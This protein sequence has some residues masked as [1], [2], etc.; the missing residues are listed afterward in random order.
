M[1]DKIIQL[2][3]KY[4]ELIKYG[5]FGVLTT[6]VNYVCYYILTRG[7]AIG[8][9]TS[10][11]IAFILS[12]LF[13]YVTNRK[14]VFESVTKGKEQLAEFAKFCLARVSGLFLDLGIMWFFVSYLGFNQ[15]IQDLVV[16][17]CSNI[18]II[19]LNFVISKVF[20]FKKKAGTTAEQTIDN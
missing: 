13:A 5:I 10:T 8:E 6:L 16:K 7:F 12:I 17:L 14:W 15:G 9:L 4:Q 19:I 18:F 1:I 3:K 20:V 2:I 11:T